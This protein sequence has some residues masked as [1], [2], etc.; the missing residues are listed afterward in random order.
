[1]T[2][3]QELVFEWGLTVFTQF[4][5]L[6][7]DTNIYPPSSETMNVPIP[8]ATLFNLEEFDGTLVAL[9]HVSPLSVDREI[10]PF[11]LTATKTPLP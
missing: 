8:Y 10:K 4:P 5:P 3:F 9:S 7:F 1:M 11:E 2:R 6:S